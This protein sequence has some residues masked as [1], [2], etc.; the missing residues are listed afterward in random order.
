M[1]L[2]S[3]SAELNKGLVGQTRPVLEGIQRR[4]VE[5][6]VK[7]NGQNCTESRESFGCG[8]ERRWNVPWRKVTW[9][10]RSPSVRTHVR[11]IQHS[12]RATRTYSDVYVYVCAC[13]RLWR[14]T[15]SLRNR[16]RCLFSALLRC[17]KSSNYDQA[18]L[19]PSDRSC[20]PLTLPPHLDRERRSYWTWVIKT[21]G[22]WFFSLWWFLSPFFLPF[23]FLSFFFKTRDS[24]FFLS[25]RSYNG[26][27]FRSISM[28]K[29]WTRREI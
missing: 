21:R 6:V 7:A 25:D 12:R 24:K 15:G 8:V 11:A 1:D 19:L 14:P 2:V 17:L 20:F 4:R 13:T 29:L 18:S 5:T 27:R 16:F 3:P 26:Y 22:L 28:S 23:L 9:Q 10:V